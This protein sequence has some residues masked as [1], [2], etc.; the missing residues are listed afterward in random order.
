[1]TP[2][3]IKPATRFTTTAGFPYSAAG[4]CSRAVLSP[5]R[6]ECFQAFALRARGLCYLGS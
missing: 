5:L 2:R 3:L 1:M 4:A 6:E